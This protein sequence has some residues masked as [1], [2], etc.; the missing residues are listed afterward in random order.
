MGRE[1][2]DHPLAQ[3]GPALRMLRERIGLVQQDLADRLGVNKGSV[4]RIEQS[5]ANPTI[6]TVGRYLVAAEA[7][8]EDLVEALKKLRSEPADPLQRLRSPSTPSAQGGA[9]QGSTEDRVDDV[10]RRLA[11][12]LLDLYRSEFFQVHKRL[13]AIEAKLT[14]D[15]G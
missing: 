7:T 5:S 3:V 2:Q 9:L 10:H 4:S 6:D 11:F 13:T 15:P 14:R 8:S 1:E 12:D